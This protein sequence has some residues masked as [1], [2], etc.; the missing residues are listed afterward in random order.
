MGGRAETVA[1]VTSSLEGALGREGLFA[2]T[3][4]LDLFP[5]GKTGPVAEFS[6][7][8]TAVVLRGS[9]L[10]PMATGKMAKERTLK[11]AA[12]GGKQK[13]EKFEGEAA[14]VLEASFGGGAYEQA[15]LTVNV[16]QYSEEEVEVKEGLH[17]L[18][19]RHEGRLCRPGA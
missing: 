1:L 5:T 9:V 16:T 6:C 8:A 14:D 17:P 2:E 15:G 12:S 13:P 18:S 4:A 7:G 19:P 10:T 3:V 11:F